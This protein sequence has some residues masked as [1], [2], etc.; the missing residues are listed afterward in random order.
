MKPEHAEHRHKR[1]AFR[2]ERRSDSFK[3]CRNPRNVE[4]KNVK[5]IEDSTTE[6]MDCCGWL[7]VTVLE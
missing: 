3:F 7:D 4:R 6:F 1:S 2:S 5:F